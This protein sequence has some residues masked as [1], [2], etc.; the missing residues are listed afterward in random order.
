MKFE[1]VDTLLRELETLESASKLLL[2]ARQALGGLR[3]PP[4]A[5]WKL[6]Y[7]LWADS[8]PHVLDLH[9]SVPEAQPV[10]L[11]A[12][13]IGL[14]DS[15]CVCAVLLGHPRKDPPPPGP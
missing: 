9:R 13:R 2:E 5:Y 10:G 4:E 15:R 7:K 14:P 3:T 8:E 12:S 11:R 6:K 1:A